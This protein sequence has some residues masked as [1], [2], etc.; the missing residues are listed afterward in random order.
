MKQDSPSLQLPSLRDGHMW[1][2][3]CY[4]YSSLVF[5]LYFPIIKSENVKKNAWLQANHEDDG[6]TITPSVRQEAT[7]CHPLLKGGAGSLGVC[8]PHRTL[9]MEY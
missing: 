3:R 9:H 5:V 6:E 2:R 1:G 7:I 8:V 4:I